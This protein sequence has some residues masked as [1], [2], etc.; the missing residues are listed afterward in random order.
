[1]SNLVNHARH[2]LELINEEPDVIE[3]YL[4]IIQTF[5]DMGHSGTSAAHAIHTLTRLLQFK[6][7]SPL[8]NNP[9]EWQYHGPD[10]WDGT[11]GIWQN[12]RNGEAFS[13]DGGETYY[14]L[15]ERDSD[16]HTIHHSEKHCPDP[17][18]TN[19]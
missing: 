17:Q 3:H 6:E 14:L 13:N 18:D 8:T 15:S 10:K 12:R 16:N 9:N 19:P 5:A 11:D 7:L 2:E 4:A 1:M